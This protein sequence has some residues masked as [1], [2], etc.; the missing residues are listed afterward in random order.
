MKLEER[1]KGILNVNSEEKQNAKPFVS[2]VVPAYNEAAIVEKNLNKICE[3]MESIE[4]EYKWELIFVNDGSTDGTGEIAE[5]FAKTMDNVRVLHHIVNFHLGQALRYAF[6]NC[7]GEYVVTMDLDLSYAPDH[8]KKLLDTIRE[9]KAKIVLASPFMKGGK[10]TNVPWIRRVLSVWANR[11]LSLTAKGKI[12]TLTGMVR[13]YDCKFIKS[14]N[15]RSWDFEINLEILYKAQLLR[16]R[17]V[18][19]PA[20]L[21]W[22]FQKSL[23]RKRRSSIKISRGVMSNLFFGFLFRPF[24]FFI[25]P[26]LAFLTLSFY[27]IIWALIYT[28]THSA[29]L[30]SSS[31]P[32]DYRLADAV[33]AAF[34]QAPHV[35]FVGGISLIVGVQ[36]VS[37]GIISLQN[38]R[39]FE[40]LFYLGTNIYKYTQRNLPDSEFQQ[41]KKNY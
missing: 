35:F 39:Y 14:L 38:K 33:A 36:L 4:D 9:T 20:H 34:N 21:D 27:P 11:F 32:I 26:G 31:G 3:F 12:R 10:V 30:P 37:L 16:A 17:V 2:I 24:M 29:K 18:E 23:E 8:I 22:G 6:K 19:I 7:S 1:Q 15:L 13:A 25:L 28:F 5:S 40:E 41:Y